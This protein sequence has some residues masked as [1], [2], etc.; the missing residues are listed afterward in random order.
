MAVCE[1]GLEI[2]GV[3]FGMRSEFPISCTAQYEPFLTG[4]TPDYLTEFRLVDTLPALPEETRLVSR[5]LSFDVVQL[6]DGSFRRLFF[7]EIHGRKCY[8][9]AEYDFEAHRSVCLCL[10]DEDR[11][12]NHM[13][14][15][16]FHLAWEEILLREGRLI[17]HACLVATPEGGILFSG[18][19]G[20]GKSTQG[21]LWQT[22]A[23]ARVINGDRPVL[24]R[25]NGLWLACGSP[26][27][28]SSQYY[29]NEAVP[30]RALVLLGQASDCSI[31][32]MKPGEAFRGLW[33]GMTVSDWDPS[34]AKLAV[35][36]C[37][38]AA[39]ELPFYALDCTPDEAAVRL[40]QNTL[41]VTGG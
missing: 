5:Q 2:A 33:K 25:K 11:N 12:V 40:L 22:H 29:V 38:A 36:L 30:V 20:I 3:C 18:P 31:R 4:R 41:E 28:G 15:A 14:G 19:S 32:P 27:A 16:F 10:R 35:E 26:Y 7:D 37:A 39:A 21:E 9:V 1:C 23:G 34:Q 17:A 8:A 13:R 6:P 24:Y